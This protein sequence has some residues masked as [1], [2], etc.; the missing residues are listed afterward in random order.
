MNN[1]AKKNYTALSNVQHQTYLFVFHRRE[2]DS[3]VVNNCISLNDSSISFRTTS[4]TSNLSETEC[5]FSPKCAALSAPYIDLTNLVSH[6]KMTPV[7]TS[8]VVYSGPGNRSTTVHRSPERMAVTN[9]TLPQPSRSP[10]C[11]REPDARPVVNVLHRTT[12]GSGAA[13]NAILF[14][15]RYGRGYG[16]ET[17]MEYVE[18]TNGSSPKNKKKDLAPASPST[19][20]GTSSVDE[21]SLDSGDHLVAIPGNWQHQRW[22]HWEKETMQKSVEQH[23]QLTLV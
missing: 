15:P 7:K 9:H 22:M 4:S 3:D 12:A 13:T 16:S 21:A 19:N 17:V 6:E 20:S 10:G 8:D 2:N 14:P 1:I 11:M 18:I 23:E 5:G